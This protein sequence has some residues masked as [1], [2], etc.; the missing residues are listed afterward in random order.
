M[1]IFLHIF[2]FLVAF[3]IA[4]IFFLRFLIF[5]KNQGCGIMSL[6]FML[7]IVLVTYLSYYSITHLS[8]NEFVQEF[9]RYTELTYPSSGKI[10]EKNNDEAILNL[11]PYYFGVIEMDTLDYMKI[12]HEVQARRDS[13]S[14]NDDI[15]YSNFHLSEDESSDIYAYYDEHRDSYRIRFWLGFH[16][17]KRIIR[18]GLE[19]I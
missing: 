14:T 10:I 5:K 3:V 16:K 2:I 6:V 13:L 15:T 19:S 17:N 4:L 7:W 9:E 8:D 1:I 18:C 11:D 12:L